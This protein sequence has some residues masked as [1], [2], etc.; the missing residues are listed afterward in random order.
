MQ[1]RQTSVVIT[2]FLIL[3]V[4]FLMFIYL[5]KGKRR[6]GAAFFMENLYICIVFV[7][8]SILLKQVIF[9]L[10]QNSLAAL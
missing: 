10:L 3:F 7:W 1:K 4:S 8:F 2:L 9:Y 6:N 5:W